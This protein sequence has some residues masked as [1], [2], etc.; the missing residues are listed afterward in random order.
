MERPS[1]K[2]IKRLFALS[3]N[4]C[5]FPNCEC[6]I[7]DAGGSVLGQVCHIKA[8]RPGGP[9]YDASQ[10]D[11]ERHGFSNLI[12][13]CGAHNKVIDDDPE[14]YTVPRL[15]EI[16]ARHE[17]VHTG[18]AEPSDDVTQRLLL[19][20]ASNT[21]PQGSIIAPQSPSGGQF[22]HS[23][24]NIVQGLLRYPVEG[25]KPPLHYQENAVQ[26][27]VTH[28]LRSGVEQLSLAQFN[29]A[30]GNPSLRDNQDPLFEPLSLPHVQ[31]A[32]NAMIRDDRVILKD[33]NLVFARP[34]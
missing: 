5:A 19:T 34:S 11:E 30:L 25:P 10:T 15:H 3:G 28:I 24:T 6:P 26:Q 1:D 18:G 7:A 21:V 32:L 23:I 20:I 17:A 2:T 22:A 16:K 9:R 8:K 12:L 29:S 27:V 14:S 31:D 33:G 4:R 13:M